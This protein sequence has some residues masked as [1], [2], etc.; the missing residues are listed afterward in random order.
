MFQKFRS[1]TDSDLV[2]EYKQTHSDDLENE[3]ISRYQKHSQA[4]AAILFSRY[5]FLYQ[6]EFDDLYCIILA[7]TFIAIK[8]F[9]SETGDFYHYWKETAY[10]EV[11]EYISKFSTVKNGRIDSKYESTCEPGVGFLREHHLDLTDD[12]LSSFELEDVLT[13]PKNR[14]D[15]IDA[16]IFRLY[17]AGYQPIEIASTTGINYNSVRYRIRRVKSK[18][19]NILFNQ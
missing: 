6:V 15:K 17:L 5:K 13:N 19:A 14:I 9:S 2:F 10:N 4:I 18:I 3:I 1:R 8:G 16:E 7:S 12:Y 11:V